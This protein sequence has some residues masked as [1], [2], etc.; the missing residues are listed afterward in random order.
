MLAVANWIHET[1]H[2]LLPRAEQVGL[3]KVHHLVVLLQVVLQR[4]PGQDDPTQGPDPVDG[5]VQGGLFVFEQVALVTDDNVRA[6]VQQAPE[7]K[8]THS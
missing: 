3:D 6:R 2:E 4:G 1:V 5:L 7:N 8:R